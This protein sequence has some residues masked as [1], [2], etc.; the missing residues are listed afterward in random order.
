MSA[1][2]HLDHFSESLYLTKNQIHGSIPTEYGQ[3]TNLKRLQLSRN[4]LEGSVNGPELLKP[5]EKLE[6]IGLGGNKLSGPIPEEIGSMPAMVY[7]NIPYNDFTGSIPSTW[8]SAKLE[9]VSLSYNELSGEIP[10]TLTGL[11]SLK[12]LFLVGNENLRGS[13]S[14]VCVAPYVNATYNVTANGMDMTVDCESVHCDC[15]DC[16]DVRPAVVVESRVDEIATIA[17]ATEDGFFTYVVGGN[18]TETNSTEIVIVHTNTSAAEVVEEPENE[19]PVAN[20]TEESA[21]FP[22]VD[23]ASFDQALSVLNGALP[24]AQ[25]SEPYGCQSIS[26]GFQCYTSGWSIDFELSNSDCGN[27][28]PTTD[29]DLVALYPFEGDVTGPSKVGSL[30]NLDEASFWATSCGLAECDGVI[31]NGQ[32]YYRNTYPKQTA[33]LSPTWWPVPANSMI[34]VQWIRVDASGTAIVLA[35][36]A[37]FLVA[38]QCQ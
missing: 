26:V 19:T 13:V 11:D 5:L 3:L 1:P 33:P 27:N 20:T 37:P 28:A 23:D 9:H 12:R 8:N 15:C 25:A 32:V 16:G 18:R 24:A 35:E 6:I 2:I 7:I 29:Y 22:F 14:S 21:G 31:A 38:N 36:S 34:Q 30:K 4:T 17:N 10:E